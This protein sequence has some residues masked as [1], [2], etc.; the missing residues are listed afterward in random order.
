MFQLCSG[1]LKSLKINN[2]R[3][4]HRLILGQI[5]FISLKFSQNTLDT[6]GGWWSN[7]N[8]LSCERWNSGSSTQSYDEA[9]KWKRALKLLFS[10]EDLWENNRTKIQFWAVH[11]K[12]NHAAFGC[13]RIDL[14]W[15]G[16]RLLLV[17]PNQNHVEILSHFF[18]TIIPSPN[19]EG[20][21]IYIMGATKLSIYLAFPSLACR[22]SHVESRRCSPISHWSPSHYIGRT[23]LSLPKHQSA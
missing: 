12:P 13:Q 16:I 21:A 1:E 22:P 17:N 4:V 23:H 5:L 18:S 6:G 10:C 19:H 3:S 9:R 14:F 11:N 20:A 7:L 8:I 15:D 2:L